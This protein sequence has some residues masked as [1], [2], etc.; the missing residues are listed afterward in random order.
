MSNTPH[1]DKYL[2]DTHLA[3]NNMG[4]DSRWGQTLSQFLDL[5]KAASYDFD[6]ERA[7]KHLNSME[8]LWEAK[9][10]PIFSIELR[11]ELH[12]EKGKVLSR[13]GR[14]SHAI[15]EYQKL[16]DYCQDE[17]LLSK[18][19]DVFLEIGQLMSKTGEND[20]ALGYIH[21]ALSGFRRLNDASGICRSLRNLGAIYINL[22][23]FDD[24][25]AT[26][27]EA[28]EIALQEKLHIIYADLFNNL[29]TI[30]NIR[31]DWKAALECYFKAK[32]VFEKEGEIRKSAYTLNNIGITLLEQGQLINARDSFLSALQ[33]AG[34]VKDESLILILNLSLTDLSLKTGNYSD[35][36]R[37]CQ[38]TKRY[39]EAKE[40]RNAQWVEM[41]KLAGKIAYNNKEFDV[42]QKYFD[43]A[44]LL[45]EELGLQFNAAEL[46][47]EKGNLLFE[48]DQ[49]MEALQTLERAFQLFH[50]FKA[51]GKVENT[52]NLINSIEE[53]YL[54]VFDAMA[55]R[56]D[57]KDP[58]TKG[59]SDRVA[60]LTL[61]ICQKLSLSDH[62]T[63]A[64]V[65]GA[66]LHDIGKLNIA[67]ELLKKPEK[68]TSEEFDEIKTHP[69]KGVQ[70]LNG[71]KLP[72]DILPMIRHHHEKFDGS[73]YPSGLKG[74][75][76]PSS[77]RI[78]AVADV[79]DAL[80][81][82]RPYRKMFSADK[83]LRIMKEE[84]T[85]SF[86]QLI[87][88]TLVNLVEGG[89]IDNIINRKT[90][91]DEMYRIWSQCRPK[92]NNDPSNRES[93]AAISC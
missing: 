66:L 18:R 53:L 11:Y 91:S 74:E 40:L 30:K 73:G 36:S 77:A 83:A 68:L 15:A 45:A 64:T 65:A 48:T 81:S 47:F 52:E 69:D 3:K 46:F 27:D 26:Y 4:I 55:A 84:M 29:G 2:V 14:Y 25:E 34:T 86:D 59:H 17:K 39:L 12:S 44:F 57:H 54:K 89:K 62:E 85:F 76:I 13:L 82:D 80:T 6:Y 20:K 51:S 79:F 71:I 72:W 21:R 90:E 22:G 78:I 33:V 7:L 63:K 88:D 67:D 92:N 28:I 8:E 42:A 61:M 19:V 60:H 50:Q 35:A 43:E 16:L 23:E 70:V 49:H 9:G 41:R 31:G 5:A 87:L 1:K 56:A 24:V 75:L 93:V 58:Y 37:Y 32:D 10:L 38:A